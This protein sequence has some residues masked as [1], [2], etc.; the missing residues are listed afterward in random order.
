M[1]EEKNHELTSPELLINSETVFSYKYISAETLC[2]CVTLL[3]NSRSNRMDSVMMYWPLLTHT[4]SIEYIC[5]AV[6]FYSFIF[7]YSDIT[8]SD[9]T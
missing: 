4:V 6:F 1:N 3:G 8:L 5:E 9:S 7:H 2:T